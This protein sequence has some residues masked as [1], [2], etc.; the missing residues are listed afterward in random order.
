PK[1][2]KNSGLVYAENAL[3][4]TTEAGGRALIL[5]L[6]PGK[7][8][9]WD[10]FDAL[11]EGFDVRGFIESG[12]KEFEE[13]LTKPKIQLADWRSSK[14]YT[15]KAPER[16]WL[17]N[18]TFPMGSVSVIAAMG[19]AGK[20]MLGLDLALKVAC[21]YEPDLLNPYPMAFGN[22][23]VQHGTAV[24][25]SAEDDRDE[26]FRRLESLDPA[27]ERRK[28]D[29][30]IVV[31]MPDIG[32]PMPLV[33]SGKK[34]PEA[35]PHYYELKRQLLGLPDLKLVIIDPLGCF[36]MA[37]TTKD[38]VAGAFTLGLFASLA[39]ETG[40]AVLVM[41]HLSK[42]PVS[43]K[44]TITVDTVRS[45]IKGVT[46]IVDG[47]RLS[48][49]LWPLDKDNARGV[50]KAM[51]V[52]WERNKVVGGAVVKTNAPV[53]MEIK[54]FIR[55]E[56]GLLISVNEI[57]RNVK[58]PESELRNQLFE[59]IKKAAEKGRP[60]TATS[61]QSPYNRKEE[62]S[63]E[64]RHLGRQKLAK[65]TNDLLDSARIF[66]TKAPGSSVS[67]WLDVLNGPFQMG[68][69]KFEAGFDIE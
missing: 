4:A 55:N 21:D 14:A 60:F 68:C 25:L 41:H 5:D 24:V 48:Y 64:L 37:D 17:V 11:K 16:E 50:C 1:T 27:G 44:K 47:S 26:I 56:N 53:D 51:S 54:T 10:A 8:F 43:E 42:L 20:G 13:K 63:I 3:I 49:A 69:G 34:N 62:L 23:V 58:T 18:H 57:L 28:K 38:Q 6:P 32:G 12:F 46:A 30:L 61:D 52:P 65:L 31:P 15:G 45:L 33:V 35:T 66:K 67:K 40:A 29:R 59:D 36:V 7:P 9:K 19:G 39:K 2:G 22:G